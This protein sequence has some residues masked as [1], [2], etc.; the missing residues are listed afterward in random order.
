MNKKQLSKGLVQYIDEQAGYGWK[1][2]HDTVYFARYK[3]NGRAKDFTDEQGTVEQWQ[4]EYEIRT[5]HA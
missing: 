2:K 3:S 1:I 4:W 5:K